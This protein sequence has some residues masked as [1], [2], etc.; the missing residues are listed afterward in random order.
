MS[1]FVVSI[2]ALGLAAAPRPATPR[3]VGNVHPVAGTPVTY[4][5]SS[6]ERGLPAAKLRYRCG[7]DA[8]PLHACRATASIKLTA[9]RHFLRVQ[10]VDQAGRRSA[11]ARLTIV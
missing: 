5:F 8:A 2:L 7:L 1:P 4:V 9:G 6:T 11:V 3:I 10:A